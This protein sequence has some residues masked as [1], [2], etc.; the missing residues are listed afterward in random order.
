M[1]SDRVPQRRN[2]V[3]NKMPVLRAFFFLLGAMKPLQAV[4]KNLSFNHFARWVIIGRNQFPHLSP[5]QPR[6]DQTSRRPDNVFQVTYGEKM[7]VVTGGQ[8]FYLA[9]AE[10]SL[11]CPARTGEK[12]SLRGRLKRPC[13]SMFEARCL[14]LD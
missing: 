14:R 3:T 4:L 9:F 11:C 5:R 8:D 2:S 10:S 12:S 13:R 7:R 6:E 1:E